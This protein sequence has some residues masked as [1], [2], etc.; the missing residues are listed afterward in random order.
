MDYR[1]VYYATK[2]GQ[3]YP[4]IEIVYK[5]SFWRSLFGLPEI[6]K[7]WEKRDGGGWFNKET[8]EPASVD[9][10]EDIEQGIYLVQTTESYYDIH[11]T[12]ETWK[13]T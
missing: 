5:N 10:I 13:R 3:G 2:N 6:R 11:S 1:T 4:E 7:E 8:N 9:E 12:E